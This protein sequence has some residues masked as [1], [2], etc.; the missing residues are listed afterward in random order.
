[1][2]A[3]IQPTPPR[4]D[5]L[6]VSGIRRLLAAPPPLQLEWLAGLSHGE[7]EREFRLLCAIKRLCEL[8]RADPAFRGQ[9]AASPREALVRYRL[10]LDPDEVQPLLTTE[11]VVP[12]DPTRMP[13]A[14][15]RF[16]EFATTQLT[17]PELGHAD[18]LTSN[19]R[20][21]AWQRRQRTRVDSQLAPRLVD[22]IPHLAVTFELSQGCSV[23]C[24]FCGISAPRLGDLFLYTAENARLWRGALDVLADLLGEAA[25]FGLCYWATEPMDNPDYERFCIDFHERFGLFPQ[26]TT[27]LPLKD[28]ARTRALLHLAM[29]RGCRVNRFSILSR[30]MLDRVFEEFSPEE[31]AF[32]PLVLINPESHT[33]PTPVGRALRRKGAAEPSTLSDRGTIACTSGFLFNMVDRTVKLISP[34]SA[35]ERWVDGYIVYAEGR[36]HDGPDLAALLSRMIEEQMPLEVRPEHRLAFRP[37]LTYGSLPDGFQVST[38][39]KRQSFRGDP[40]LVSLGELVREGTKTADEVA[41]VLDICGVPAARTYSTLNALLEG[42]VLDEEQLALTYYHDLRQE[43]NPAGSGRLKL[44]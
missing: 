12:S 40:Y 6:A 5:C 25:K 27:A 16:H 38:W 10:D 22:H 7:L 39:I 42:G 29:E 21:R 18:D 3:S 15:R 4:P 28:P 17:W 31:L 41:L 44:Q 34:C 30:R 8:R 11:I 2:T 37:D 26:T 33:Q 36:F 23:G 14:L 13:L 32:V 35:N 9:L 43:A 1:M 19:P 24:R 20:F